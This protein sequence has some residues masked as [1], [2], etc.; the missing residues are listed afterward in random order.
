[1]PA[2]ANVPLHGGEEEDEGGVA[3]MTRISS[4][5]DPFLLLLSA[6]HAVYDY[7]FSAVHA[8]LSIISSP[9]SIN[10]YHYYY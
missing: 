4:T 1:M 10:Y 3:T 6:V 8:V 7:L 2:E 5:S 9:C